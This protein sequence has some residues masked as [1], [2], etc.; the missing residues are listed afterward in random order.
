V[1]ISVDYAETYFN[2]NIQITS[3]H[4]KMVV[5]YIHTYGYGDRYI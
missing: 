5:T 4:Y 2:W 3:G 1:I